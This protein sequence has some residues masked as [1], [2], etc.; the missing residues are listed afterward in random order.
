MNPDSLKLRLAFVIRRHRENR[1][2]S[3]E[4]FADELGLHRAYYGRVENGQNLTLQTF[5]LVARGLGI[6]PS[7][8]LQEAENL[9]L[10]KLA[11]APTTRL[12]RG[13]PPGRHR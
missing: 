8:L 5:E 11:E 4:A 1:Q 12:R 9:D 10:S 2:F 6:R 7:K 13:R 3:Q